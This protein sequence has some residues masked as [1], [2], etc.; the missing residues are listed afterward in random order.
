MSTVSDPA[1]F[2]DPTTPQA[3]ALDWITNDD[4]IEPVLCPN[5]TGIGCSTGRDALIQRYILTTF[6]FGTNGEN[7]DN[8]DGWLTSSIVC[9][10]Y[11]IECDDSDTPPLN[12]V[13]QIDFGK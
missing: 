2:N 9:D 1:L 6:Y 7:W 12:C 5:Q 10:W 11:G 13:D 4:A 8:S 3:R